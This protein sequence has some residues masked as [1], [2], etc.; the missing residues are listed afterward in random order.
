MKLEEAL[1]LIENSKGLAELTDTLQRIAESYGFAHFAFLDVGHPGQDEPFA[2]ATTEPDWDSDYRS[3]G[4]VKMDPVVMKA[5]RWN[6]PFFWSDVQLPEPR[7]RR[8]PG[9]VQVMDAAHCHGLTNGL[10]IPFHFVDGLGRMN[11]SCCTF[12]WRD[13]W[14]QLKSAVQGRKND[15][16]IIMLYWSQAVMTL[17]AKEIHRS[18]RFDRDDLDQGESVHLTTRE[19]E[20]LIWAARGKTTAEVADIFSISPETVAT[21]YKTSARKMGTSSKAH[22]VVVALYMGLID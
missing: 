15:L 12:F 11:S 14:N 19:R 22:S 17:A 21:F 13:R 5:R 20:A 6:L 16:H 3:N 4:F 2:I 8:L 1:S 7:G 18:D 9:E 10:V